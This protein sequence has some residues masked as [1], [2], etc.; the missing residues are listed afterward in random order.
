MTIQAIHNHIIFR[1]VDEVNSKG[2]FEESM[3]SGF[4]IKGG[5]DKSAKMPRWA[6]VLNVGPTCEHV[7]IGDK[8]LI[9]ALRW[10]E[11]V[12]YQEQRF[13]KTDESQLVG[14]ERDG[15][16]TP[17]NEHI[18]FTPIK[19]HITPS[20]AGILIVRQT[21]DDTPSGTV[22]QIADGCEKE[23]D[24]G[25]IYYD[26]ASFFDTFELNNKEYSFIKEE[27]VIVYAPKE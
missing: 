18:I 16:F 3:K 22:T 15:K 8:I 5:Y 24:G 13:W 12:K 7:K 6:N 17:I 11:G 21:T 10:T 20:A 23:L 27:K 2:E 19:E 25:T 1:F 14:F 26:N 4:Y 9:P